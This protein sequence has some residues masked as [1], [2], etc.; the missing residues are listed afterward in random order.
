LTSVSEFL[1]HLR[2]KDIIV[3]LEGDQL[4]CSA[5]P[6]VLNANL[7]EELQ[8]RKPDIVS[9][10]RMAQSLAVRPRAVVPLQPGG[11]RPPIFGVPGAGDWGSCYRALSQALGAEQ[12]FYA[13]EPPGLDDTTQALHEVAD[14]ADYFAAAIREF[15]PNG[16]FL[17]AGYCTGGAVAFELARRL[18]ARAA[19]VALLI[20]L[21]SPYPT[22]Y[23]AAANLRWKASRIRHHARCIS[24]LPT[25]ARL[26]YIASLMRYHLSR[27]SRDALAAAKDPVA[28]RVKVVAEATIDAIRRYQPQHFEGRVALILPNERCMDSLE[29]PIEWQRHAGALE[30]F[31]GPSKC[32]H[33]AMLSADFAP[34][35]ARLID[36]VSVA[37]SSVHTTASAAENASPTISEMSCGRW[38]RQS[39]SRTSR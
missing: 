33:L 26:P 11:T 30:I 25:A 1:E 39:R 6:G 19:N 7:R 24:S 4:R 34:A 20:L 38:R 22:A 10:L 32:E 35:L 14:L 31:T 15:H 9:F 18:S 13:L 17:I 2:T 12:P 16:P 37:A 23:R 8:A 27:R 21:D 5:P 3:R 28:A 36:S 29:R